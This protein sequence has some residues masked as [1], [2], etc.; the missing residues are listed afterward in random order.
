M[1]RNFKTKTFKK[2][3]LQ[4]GMESMTGMANLLRVY[5]RILLPTRIAPGAFD[6][7]EFRA[8]FDVRT[9]KNGKNLIRSVAAAWG[10][11][12]PCAAGPQS[13]P[14]QAARDQR[15]A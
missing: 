13:A 6:Q 2:T 7:F 10:E 5:T 8:V 12:V 9:P 15:I 14:L 1:G 11:P 4:L 3:R